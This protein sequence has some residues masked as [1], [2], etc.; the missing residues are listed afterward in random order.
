MCANAGLECISGKGFVLTGGPD[1]TET[2]KF[3]EMMDKFFYTFNDSNYQSGK[4]SLKHFQYPYRSGENFRLEVRHCRLLE[5]L[6]IQHDK[7]PVAERRIPSISLCGM[8]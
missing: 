6:I 5:K 1:A 7:I 8:V 4:H 3:V 2:A